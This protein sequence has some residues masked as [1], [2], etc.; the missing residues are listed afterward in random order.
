MLYGSSMVITWTI[1]LITSWD[2]NLAELLVTCFYLYF[3]SFMRDVNDL[4]INISGVTYLENLLHSCHRQIIKLRLSIQIQINEHFIY[5][6]NT[7]ARF[8]V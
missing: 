3:K 6:I 8:E 4:M 7:A 1:S 5:S 2:F